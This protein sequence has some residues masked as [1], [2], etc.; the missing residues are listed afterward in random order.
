MPNRA[1]PAIPTLFV[2]NSGNLADPAFLE[3]RAAALAEPHIQ[4]RYET[5]R[6]APWPGPAR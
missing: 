6:S 1:S 4:P 3:W 5:C 2:A